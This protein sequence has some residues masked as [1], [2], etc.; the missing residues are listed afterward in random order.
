M[1]AWVA[2]AAIALG[3]AMLNMFSAR[4]GRKVNE[5]YVQQQ[6]EYNSPANQMSR[7]K[8]AGLNPNLIASQGNPGNQSSTPSAPDI[9]H[10]GSDLVSSYNASSV[11]QS[12]VAAQTASTSRT[13]TLESIDRIKGEVLS[14]NPILDETY[15][16][17]VI[18]AMLGTAQ[19]KTARGNMAQQQ[20]KWMEEHGME[21]MN[22]ELALLEQRFNLGKLDAKVKAE[23][24]Q[25]KDFQ[26]AILEIQ[27]KFMADGQIGPQQILEFVKLLLLKIK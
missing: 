11:A 7:F 24:I 1:P 14:R 20:S 12:Q 8:A 19:E 15:L 17:A 25:S 23:V 13:K 3:G 10:A 27:K 26:N 5:G 16:N 9:S 18:N 4:R 2:P 21:K 6:N 22:Q